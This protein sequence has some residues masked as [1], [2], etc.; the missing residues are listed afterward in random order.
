MVAK[1]LSTISWR[2]LL[3]LIA[4]NDVNNQNVIF[5][6]KKVSHA[7]YNTDIKYFMAGKIVSFCKNVRN[8]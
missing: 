6:K 8:E 1:I 2:V 5:E 4:R 3:I 7:A